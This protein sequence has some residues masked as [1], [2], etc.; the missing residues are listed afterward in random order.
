MT[1]LLGFELCPSNFG[2]SK[3]RRSSNNFLRTEERDYRANN[4]V[5][6]VLL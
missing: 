1:A 2:V 6:L 3:P 4:D 5:W